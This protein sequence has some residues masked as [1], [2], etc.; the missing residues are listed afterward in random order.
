MAETVALAK[1]MHVRERE[2]N[3]AQKAYRNSSEMFEEIATQLYTLL[4]KKETAEESYEYYLQ[5]TTPITKIKEQLRYIEILNKRIVAMQGSV[6]KARK[7]MDR[8]QEKLTSAHV[9]V[10]KFEKII[11]LRQKE[12]AETIQRY[13]KQSMDEIAIQQFLSRKNG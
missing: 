7:E 9:E 8:K 11:D 6:Q 12:Q 5:Q 1:V 13:E 2:K 10:K 4:R 3:D